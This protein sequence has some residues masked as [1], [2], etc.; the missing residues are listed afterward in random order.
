MIGRPRPLLQ[1]KC[2][3]LWAA[4]TEF[5]P[6]VKLI[7]HAGVSVSVYLQ[8]G[9]FSGPFGRRMAARHLLFFKPEHC[10]LDCSPAERDMA[11]LRDWCFAW[12]CCSH[13]C[14]RA[15]KWSLRPF[16]SE[17]DLLE[18]VHVAV[19]AL[20]RASTG[21]ISEVASFIMTYVTFDLRDPDSVAEVDSVDSDIL[22]R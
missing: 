2:V 21:L 19:S 1:K 3:D 22:G 16:V 17:K 7:G 5:A 4:A 6:M 10:P 8:D 12:C 14:S 13:I 18:S 20:M 15:L 9:L 11:E